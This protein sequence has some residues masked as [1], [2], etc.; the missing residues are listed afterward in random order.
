[1]L[2]NF[3]NLFSFFVSWY[4]ANNKRLLLQSYVV[5]VSGKFSNFVIWLSTPPLA[6]NPGVH[7]MYMYTPG[8]WVGVFPVTNISLQKCF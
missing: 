4:S 5:K 3:I 7:I 6:Q 2:K 8:F 1:V